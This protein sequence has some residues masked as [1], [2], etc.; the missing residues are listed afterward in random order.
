M[1]P[2]LTNPGE[3]VHTIQFHTVDEF[4]YN[5]RGK[6]EFTY[7]SFQ[8][9]RRLGS[10]GSIVDTINGPVQVRLMVYK[11]AVPFEDGFYEDRPELDTGVV[12]FI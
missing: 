3:I 10:G 9:E 5:R 12:P 4:G 2:K 7:G 8:R 11:S 1:D 6:L